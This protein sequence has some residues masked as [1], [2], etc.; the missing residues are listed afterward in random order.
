MSITCNWQ[1]GSNSKKKFNS[2]EFL[3]I[4][5]DCKLKVRLLGNPVKVVKIFTDDRKCIFLD[6]EETGNKLKKKYAEKLSNVSIRYAS[7]CIDRDS[8]TMKILDMPVSVARAFGSR[9]EIVGKKISSS[10]EGCDWAIGTNGKT[11]KDVRYNV[12]YLEE[13]PL[14]YTEQVMVEERMADKDL[15]KI[16]KSCSFQEAEEKL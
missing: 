1:I 15:T 12:V 11:G 14:T 13:T 3:R 2:D 5:P 4:K 6:S 16:F 8:N 10:E 7:W 9:A